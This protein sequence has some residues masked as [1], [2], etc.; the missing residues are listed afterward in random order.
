MTERKYEIRVLYQEGIQLTEVTLDE[1]SYIAGKEKI[2]DRIM[3]ILGGQEQTRLCNRLDI[4]NGT[5][6]IKLT[7][8][9]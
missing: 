7:V 3:G 9:D 4:R 5:L 8:K 6:E 2:V 1:K